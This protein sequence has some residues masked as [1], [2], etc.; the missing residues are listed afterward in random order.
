M[1]PLSSFATFL[2]LPL[3]AFAMTVMKEASVLAADG[4]RGELKSLLRGTFAVGAG[5]MVGLLALAALLVPTFLE[6]MHVDDASVGFF[7]LAAAF[8]GCVAPVFTDQLQSTRRF[9]ELG[10]LEIG[11]ALARLAVLIV[12]M[13]LRALAGFFAG[14]ATLPFFRIL[15]ATWLLRKE[16]LVPAAPFWTKPIVR[17]LAFSFLGILVYQVTTMGASLAEQTCLRT[18]LPTADSAGYFMLTRLSDL[19]HYLT[20]PILLVLFPYTA[21]AARRGESTRRAVRV[22]T[23]VTFAAATILALVYAFWGTELLSLIPNGAEYGELA[24]LLPLLVL[25]GALGTGQVFYMN[26]EVSAGR[27]RFLAWLL[28][29]NLA[30]VAALRW[31]AVFLPS[32]TAL[33]ALFLVFAA[34]RFAFCGNTFRLPK[35]GWRARTH[36]G[37]TTTTFFPLYTIST[38]SQHTTS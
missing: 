11:A 18:T 16:L 28:P 29:L 5:A 13:P 26:T 12:V 7:I 38:P 14:N 30:E 22:S 20:L 2:A 32:L 23:A 21:A 31:G 17:R 9:I 33:L 34:L 10:K 37:M 35:C 4:K 25:I 36:A 8:L 27:F 3:F 24:P 6:R 1:L 19:L 15:G